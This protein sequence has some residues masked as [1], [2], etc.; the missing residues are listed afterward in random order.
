MRE[1][2]V[3]AR[4]M[5]PLSNSEAAPSGTA[6]QALNLRERE[7]S[8]QVVGNPVPAGSIATGERLLLMVSGHRVTSQS[9][10]VKVDGTAI[11][12]VTSDIVGAQAIGSLVVIA[13]EDGFTYLANVDG[14]WTVMNP[15][16][17]VPRL[18]LTAVQSTSRATIDAYPF[19]SP[20]AQWRAP[21]ADADCTTLSAMLRAAWNSLH[22][23][24][25]AE[26]L[27]SAPVLVRWAVRLVDGSYLWM[28]EPV[29]LGDSTLA[30][31]DRVAAS[32]VSGSGGFTGTEATALT[33]SHY[34]VQV[35][36]T[37]GIA[38]VWLPLVASIDLLATDEAQLL[39]SSRQLDYRCVTRTQAPR[40]YV[41]EMGLS[42][43]SA[44]AITRQLSAS[45]WHLIARAEASS[46]LTGTDFLAAGDGL[47]LTG[48]QCDAAGSMGRVCDVTCVASAGGRLYCCTRAGDVLV[49][50]PGNALVEA[51]RCSM[52]GT[53]PLAL[54]VVTR[55][56][57][58]GG[59]GRYPVYVFGDDGIYAIPQ[60]ALG[61]LG[62]ARL[63][64]RTVIDAD[65]AP[66][67]GGG[68][69]WLMSRHGHLCRL[70]GARLDVVV[71]GADCRELA[72]CD[73]YH[74]LWMVPRDGGRALVRMTSGRM[75]WRSIEPVQLYSDARHAVA[76]T[77]T[78]TV[79][80]LEREAVGL[81]PVEWQSHP[82]PLHV[83]MGRAVHRVVWHVVSD[84]A[85]LLLKV[86]GQRGIMSQDVDVSVL[87]VTG[88][89]SRPLASPT[90]AVQARTLRLEVAGTARS[91]TLVINGELGIRN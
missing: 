67:E 15:A 72:W 75:T 17:A 56:L 44:D 9:R 57:Y 66:V 38:A 86:K 74:E 62:E 19:V 40:E 31:A 16:D 48:A 79:L 82:V 49:S 6:A 65:V 4:G 30:N 36:V 50:R 22:A 1:I 7:Q 21:L 51:H 80:D 70:T 53:V 32:V 5:V 69:V 55:P 42:R 11:T 87:T 77:A 81:L 25:T 90:L 68:D 27:Y 3:V 54:S 43:R 45:P 76:V 35:D 60:S 78:G 13:C 34:R 84:E 85:D 83:L 2:R 8:L 52:Q 88:P 59:F 58:S 24:A 37:R 26:G 63:V 10:T 64:D 47:S 18:T 29:R 14:T 71:R 12:T 23:D 61:S 41:L 39:S 28:S 46:T 89:I 73:A 33:M 91:G 20:Y